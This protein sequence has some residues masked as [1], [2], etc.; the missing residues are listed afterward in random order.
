MLRIFCLVSLGASGLALPFSFHLA[1]TMSKR[2]PCLPTF[3]QRAG[4]HHVIP[5]EKQQWDDNRSDEQSF[6]SH[7]SQVSRSTARASGFASSLHNAEAEGSGVQQ[8][9]GYIR[10]SSSRNRGA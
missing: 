7:S 1:W 8:D 10:P 6:T 3:G 5:F 2:L 4:L 9:S